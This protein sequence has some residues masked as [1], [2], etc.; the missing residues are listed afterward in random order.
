MKTKA[1]KF[2]AWVFPSNLN[3]IGLFLTILVVADA[4]ILL[5]AALFDQKSHHKASAIGWIATSIAMLVL[6]RIFGF[7]TKAPKKVSAEALK[8]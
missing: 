3:F 4:P 6:G 8:G 2:S 7:Y 1:Y 5:V